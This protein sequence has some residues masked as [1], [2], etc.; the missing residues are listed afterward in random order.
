MPIPARPLAP[1]AVKL[2][3]ADV[4]TTLTVARVAAQVAATG[5]S[6]PVVATAP[7]YVQ[8]APAR[9]E[10]P[11]QPALTEEAGSRLRS[12]A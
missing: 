8:P 12:V 6:M 10:E 9:A 5:I 4:L 11:S 3:R 7:P 2:P 1:P